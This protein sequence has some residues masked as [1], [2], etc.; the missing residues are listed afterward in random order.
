M[1]LCHDL[2]PEQGGA[3][4]G[5]PKPL[6]QEDPYRSGLWKMV[7]SRQLPMKNYAEMTMGLRVHLNGQMFMGQPWPKNIRAPPG[8]SGR[9]R[10][11]PHLQ[12]PKNLRAPPGTSGRLRAPPG[13][14]GAWPGP[15]LILKK[16]AM[17]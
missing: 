12:S 15:Y 9:L 2:G 16:M 8:A 17:V 3:K 1:N 10:V 13:A 4:M 11:E 6:F 5:P 7:I 14:A